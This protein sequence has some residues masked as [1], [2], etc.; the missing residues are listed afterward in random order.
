VGRKV[1]V[2]LWNFAGPEGE[3]SLARVVDFVIPAA[4]GS[5]AWAFPELDFKAYAAADIIR[6]AAD[7]GHGRAREVVSMIQ[8]PPAGDIWLLR[9]APEQLDAVKLD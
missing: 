3:G 5:E 9:P 1:G 8:T 7:A 6:A 4:T 2:D